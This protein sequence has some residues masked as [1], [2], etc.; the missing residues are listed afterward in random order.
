MQ[1]PNLMP[2]AG[3]VSCNDGSKVALS[4]H[5][6]TVSCCMCIQNA[7][8]FPLAM[9]AGL[10]CRRKYVC[11]PC[12][13]LSLYTFC[14]VLCVQ[15]RDTDVQHV[16]KLGSAC[17]G[18]NSSAANSLRLNVTNSLVAPVVIL[19]HARAHYLAK[20]VLTLHRWAAE[21]KCVVA[22]AVGDEW[23]GHHPTCPSKRWAV[24]AAAE[25]T[26]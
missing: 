24:D 20:T 6:Q 1:P 10:T 22:G 23:A 12:V 11:A 18:L 2:A 8:P 13:L 21:G 17:D 5:T 14:H 19:A 7:K 4:Q 25:T 3:P 16:A 9:L 26:E 15:V